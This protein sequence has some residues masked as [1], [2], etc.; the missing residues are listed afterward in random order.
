MNEDTQIFLATSL[1]LFSILIGIIGVAVKSECE[2]FNCCWG[3]LECHR[4]Q[5]KKDEEISDRV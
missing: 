4:K 5:N 2:H 1:S 3:A